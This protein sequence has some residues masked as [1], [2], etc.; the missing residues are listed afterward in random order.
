MLSPIR[1]TAMLSVL[2]CSAACA[3]TP[4]TLPIPTAAQG[5]SVSVFARG[6]A[7]QYTQPDSVAVDGAHVFVGYGD[8]NAP[9]GSDGKKTQ[10]VQYNLTGQIEWIY[11]VTGHNDGLKVDPYQHYLW[12]LQNEDANPNVVAINY[13]THQQTPFTFAAPPPHGGGYDDIVFRAGK[14]YLSASNPANNPNTGPAIVQ[15]TVGNGYS[16]SVTP[17][18]QGNAQAINVLTG[19]QTTL[20]LQDPDSMTLDPSGDLVMTSQAD[21]ELIVVRQPGDKAQSVIQVPLSSPF[22]APQLDDT[23]FTPNVDGYILVA[24]KDAN[25]IYAINKTVFAPGAAYSS[26][27][28]TSNGATRNFLGKLDISFGQ[29][30][31]VITNTGTLGGMAFVPT[32]QNQSPIQEILNFCNAVSAFTGDPLN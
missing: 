23:L 5:Y 27:Q 21:A 16:I 29:L 22:G 15:A 2:A 24:D 10:V 8:G 17:L 18:V 26:A 14:V 4:P 31:P 6:V 12:A 9:D 7:G 28:T 32:N 1:F 3:Q 11:T 25:A 30:T 13:T 20:N 19:A